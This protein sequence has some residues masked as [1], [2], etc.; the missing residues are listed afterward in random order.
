MAREDVRERLDALRSGILPKKYKDI[1]H[2]EKTY[3]ARQAFIENP[4][5]QKTYTKPNLPRPQ[6][7]RKIQQ[8][9]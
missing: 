8:T 4:D 6:T 2:K 3:T 9:S 5:L 7:A 1:V